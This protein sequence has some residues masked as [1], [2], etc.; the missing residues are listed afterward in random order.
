AAGAEE[1]V[2]VV[3]RQR[4]GDVVDHRRPGPGDAVE[5]ATLADQ[6]ARRAGRGTQKD[7]R[8]ARLQDRALHAG[9]AVQRA[10][11]A[12]EL[13]ELLGHALGRDH[14]E[15]DHAALA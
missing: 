9:R 8:T 12:D 7:L 11:L 6:L 3:R 2:V 13:A 15:R 4:G 5:P 10:D 14:L 1:Q